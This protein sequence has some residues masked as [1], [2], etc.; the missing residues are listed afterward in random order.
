MSDSLG[1]LSGTWLPTYLKALHYGSGTVDKHLV[2][3]L[4]SEKSKAFIITG[5]SLATKTD[6]ITKVEKL[7]GGSISLGTQYYNSTHS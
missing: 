7:L 5:N 1:S 2:S 3:S 4:P 6:L